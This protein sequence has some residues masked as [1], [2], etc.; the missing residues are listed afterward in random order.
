MENGK[1]LMQRREGDW[2]EEENSFCPR[3]T[4]TPARQ[5]V[6]DTL[7]THPPPATGFK[8]TLIELSTEPE[9]SRPLEMAR[10]VTLLS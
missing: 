10:Q 5:T 9:K 4:A 7:H 3:I 6:Q 1:S 8:L 2:R